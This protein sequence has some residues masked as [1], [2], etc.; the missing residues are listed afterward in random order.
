M[1]VGKSAAT[2]IEGAPVVVVFLRMPVA[3]PDI[4]TP[5]ILTTVKAV[6]PVASPVWVALVTLAVLA[7]I[8]VICAAVA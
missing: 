8:A 3:K 1:R 5:F 6:D 4:N 7:S 2:A